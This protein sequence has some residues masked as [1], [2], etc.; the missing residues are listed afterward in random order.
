MILLAPTTMLLVR[1]YGHIV[2][3]YN[4]L[5]SVQIKQGQFITKEM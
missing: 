2:L 4:I 5:K 3:D 1:P